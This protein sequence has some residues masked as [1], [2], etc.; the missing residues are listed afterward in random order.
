[1]NHT[2]WN[3]E[4]QV[5]K[6][7]GDL[8]ASFRRSIGKLEACDFWTHGGRQD[9]GNTNSFISIKTIYS[10]DNFNYFFRKLPFS[11]NWE[12]REYI[13]TPTA[14]ESWTPVV[15][16]KL[17]VKRWWHTPYQIFFFENILLMKKFVAS[18]CIHRVWNV[19]EMLISLPNLI[20]SVYFSEN[21]NPNDVSIIERHNIHQHSYL[22]VYVTESFQLPNYL[23]S[24][25]I[26]AWIMKGLSLIFRLFE[27][28]VGTSGK[29]K[30]PSTVW[31][32]KS[33]I[34]LFNYLK[35]QS[36]IFRPIF[37]QRVLGELVLWKCF[38]I[39]AFA[40]ISNQNRER[41]GMFSK[42]K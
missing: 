38:Y 32:A 34:F 18:A 20:K 19:K 17:E 35:L 9:M 24:S 4:M 1:M 30:F 13:L 12:Y 27:G 2:F 8:G 41:R 23:P 33:V 42:R 21:P 3:I 39:F 14:H 6:I 31:N 28:A 11:T 40:V 5:K 29:V 22:I 37:L 36:T 25:A 26:L 7:S 10:L 16:K 15:Y